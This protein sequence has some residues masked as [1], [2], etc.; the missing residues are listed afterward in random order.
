MS[1]NSN[2]T[3]APIA[4]TSYNTTSYNIPSNPNRSVGPIANTSYNIP[5][6]PNKSVGPIATASSSY[7]ST[8]YD[9]AYVEAMRWADE[10][11]A[12][13][14]AQTEAIRQRNKESW[15]RFRGSTY[16]STPKM[17]KA[18]PPTIWPARITTPHAWSF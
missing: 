13:S 7:N 17:M 10:R 16:P 1:A 6:N 4:N 14:M 9:P 5:S 11:F 2:R 18:K 12:E 3:V 15:E 8:S